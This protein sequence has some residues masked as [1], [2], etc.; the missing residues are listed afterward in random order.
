MSDVVYE[1]KLSFNPGNLSPEDE[2]KYGGQYVCIPSFNE[3]RVVAADK[4]PK[5]A[6][7]AAID[8]GYADPVQFYVAPLDRKFVFLDT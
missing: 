2:T 8:A 4:D 3:P 1:G 5:K 6:H 7:Q